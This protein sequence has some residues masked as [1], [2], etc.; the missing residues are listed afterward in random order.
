[1]SFGWFQSYLSN[2]MQC[3]LF[4][5]LTS[6]LTR[7]HPFEVPQGSVL[8]PLLFLIYINDIEQTIDSDPTFLHLYADD[9]I[10]S[11]KDQNLLTNN[12]NI[13]LTRIS[14]WFI[15][16]K[17]SVNT[18][19]TDVIFFGRPGKVNECKGMLPLTFQGHDLECKEKVKH[20]GVII[21]ENMSWDL[22]GKSVR[23]MAYF[24]LNRIV[25]IKNF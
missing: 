3:T 20:L 16:N 17:L 11:S 15:K 23:K 6:D 18:S 12:L 9:T 4:N 19:K 14:E 5:E 25:Q 21:E 10:L 1:M 7:E 22:Q 13:Q 24:S 8:G 2:R